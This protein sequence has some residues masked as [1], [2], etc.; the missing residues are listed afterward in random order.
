MHWITACTMPS[1]NDARRGRRRRRSGSRR[2]NAQHTHWVRP[3]PASVCAMPGAH[4]LRGCA[5]QLH[6]P[7]LGGVGW[8]YR[9]S[10]LPA[11]STLVRAP[12]GALART[13]D[14]GFTCVSQGWDGIPVVRPCSTL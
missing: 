11:P 12:S 5:R 6:A 13:Y 9:T 7:H 1:C 10:M 4:T 3:L 14:G 2:H 8:H